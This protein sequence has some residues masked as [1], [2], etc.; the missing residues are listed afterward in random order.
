MEI[1]VEITINNNYL[2]TYLQQHR[3]N[4]Q[5]QQQQ[6]QNGGTSEDDMSSMPPSPCVTRRRIGSFNG[7][8]QQQQ[9]QQQSD[10]ATMTRDERSPD[11][12]PN[13]SL[14]RR[15]SRVLSE[16]DEG[17]LMDFLRTSGHDNTNRERKSWGSLGINKQTHL[18]LHY[19]Y[20]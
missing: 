14:R 3:Y 11:I 17:N 2:R 10:N 4:P 6:Q 5:Q 13:G 18:H 15:R 1:T 16:E 8:Q 19:I 12:T 9:Q 7:G 20:E